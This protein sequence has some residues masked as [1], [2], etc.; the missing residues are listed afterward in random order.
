MGDC[1]VFTSA[2]G[3]ASI[4]RTSRII[5]KQTIEL[6]E[7]RTF[8]AQLFIQVKLVLETIDLIRLFRR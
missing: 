6:P 3:V 1:L 7:D 4:K 8:L 5:C 2:N